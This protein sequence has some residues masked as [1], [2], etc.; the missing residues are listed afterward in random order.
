MDKERTGN[1]HFV[2]VATCFVLLESTLP[3]GKE[4]S[5]YDMKLSVAAQADCLTKEDFSK[6]EAW[7]DRYEESEQREKAEKF[8][9]VSMIKELLFEINKN[10][11]T[12]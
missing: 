5:E 12:V 7:F 4:L 8:D 3:T 10:P 1:V 6:I 2:Q 11:E 9:R